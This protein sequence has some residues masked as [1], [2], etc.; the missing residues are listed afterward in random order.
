MQNLILEFKSS[1]MKLIHLKLT[2][3]NKKSCQLIIR[4]KQKS[5]MR[6]YFKK[7]KSL[8]DKKMKFYKQ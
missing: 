6:N 4:M 8:K 3:N 2:L 1:R 7:I 5:L